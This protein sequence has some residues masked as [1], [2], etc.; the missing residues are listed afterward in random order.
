MQNVSH[1]GSSEH[2]TEFVDLGEECHGDD[3]PFSLY[4]VKKHM[5]SIV[6]LLITG[7]IELDCLFQIM[8][9][10]VLHCKIIFLC[11]QTIHYTSITRTSPSSRGRE[12]RFTSWR[13]KCQKL[14][15]IC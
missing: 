15:N 9:V 5:I 1:L 12:L 10:R 13:E 6:F 2:L 8:S 4:H 11:F 7:D 3:M 14:V